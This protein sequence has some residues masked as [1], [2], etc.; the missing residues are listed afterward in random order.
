MHLLSGMALEALVIVQGLRPS[1]RVPS[2]KG[3]SS[4][5]ILVLGPRW[6]KN[7]RPSTRHPAI[8]QNCQQMRAHPSDRN[9]SWMSVCLS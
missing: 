5:L 6:S 8:S 2:D 3:M 1:R 4:G 9:A 7:G